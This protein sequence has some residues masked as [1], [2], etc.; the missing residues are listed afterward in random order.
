MYAC[1]LCRLCRCAAFVRNEPPPEQ[2]DAHWLLDFYTSF[3]SSSADDT[4]D[5]ALECLAK[6]QG[7]FAFVIYDEVQKRVFAARCVSSHAGQQSN[8]SSPSSW[9]TVGVQG[10]CTVQRPSQIARCN[11]D[12]NSKGGWSNVQV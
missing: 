5:K 3:M 9:L 11:T 7:N 1:V 12:N 10:W 4:T 6:V 2:N 8:S